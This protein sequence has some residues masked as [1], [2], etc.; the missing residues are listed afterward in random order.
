[1]DDELKAF[2][3]AM[4]AGLLK[5]INDGNEQVLNRLGSLERDFTNTKE[6]LMRWCHRDA[7]S[8]LNPGSAN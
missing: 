7:G 1:M 4:E 6:F 2:L 3:A 5:Q 8:T